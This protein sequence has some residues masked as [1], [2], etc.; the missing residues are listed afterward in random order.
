MYSQKDTHEN[1]RR[2]RMMEGVHMSELINGG[3]EAKKRDNDQMRS[4]SN[5]AKRENALRKEF[6]VTGWL[7]R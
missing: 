2:P 6:K 7:K 5:K 1:D 4:M 3:D